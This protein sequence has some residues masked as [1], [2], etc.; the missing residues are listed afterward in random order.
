MA[1]GNH[2]HCNGAGGGGVGVVVVV[3]DVVVVGMA[4]VVGWW[5]VGLVVMEFGMVVFSAT[6]FSDFVGAG[7][8]GCGSC[9]G[10]LET[11]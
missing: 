3:M 10:S 7:G 4:L 1:F 5:W 2:V 11:T 6:N 8:Y 9:S